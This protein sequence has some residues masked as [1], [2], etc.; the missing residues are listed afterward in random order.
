[1]TCAECRFFVG[2]PQ[3]GYGT[4]HRHAPILTPDRGARW[5][6]VLPSYWCGDFQTRQDEKTPEQQTCS[7]CHSGDHH[8]T[9]HLP[10]AEACKVGDVVLVRAVVTAL[11]IHAFHSAV[12][13][14]QFQPGWPPWSYWSAKG[15]NS[16]D[17][18]GTP[19][20]HPSWW[21]LPHDYYPDR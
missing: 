12:T 8:S 14:K 18:F 15:I 13:V 1:M 17:V 16:V 2:D 5:A 3:P 6:P 11:D 7:W 19:A 9:E 21:T 20:A 10:R 4:C